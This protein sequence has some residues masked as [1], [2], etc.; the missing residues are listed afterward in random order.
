MKWFFLRKILN[1]M[2]S[3]Y[4]QIILVKYHIR[5]RKYI[6]NFIQY[7][8]YE[9]LTYIIWCSTSPRDIWSILDKVLMF[10]SHFNILRCV[11][12]VKKIVEFD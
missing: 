12:F 5:Q 2:F 6:K 11:W 7:N 4:D 9:Y 10:I 1:E 8:F 3:G